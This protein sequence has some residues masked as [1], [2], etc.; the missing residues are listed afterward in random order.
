MKTTPILLDVDVDVLEEFNL[1]CKAIKKD[2]VT[3]LNDFIRT[4][5]KSIEKDMKLKE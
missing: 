4:F 2:K 5:N 3:V 1:K